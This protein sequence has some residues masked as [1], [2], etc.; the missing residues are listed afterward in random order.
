MSVI[1]DLVICCGIE[2]QAMR[3]VNV[4]CLQAQPER[5]PAFELL[6][7]EPDATGHWVFGSQVWA[8]S[9]NHFPVG[10]L[11]VAF[12]SFRW[13]QPDKVVLLVDD[14]YHTQR[15]VFRADGRSLQDPEF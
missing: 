13:R 9:T 14:E 2:S 3:D 1:A 11:V 10:D 12:P 5:E 7:G 4:W 15:Q 6:T 8:M